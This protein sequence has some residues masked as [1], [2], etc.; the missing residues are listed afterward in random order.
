M[1]FLHI[2]FLS[3]PQLLQFLQ[4]LNID[5]TCFLL[6]AVRAKIAHTTLHNGVLPAL[7][8][9]RV[10]LAKRPRADLENNPDRVARGFGERRG[11]TTRH[12]GVRRGGAT[13]SLPKTPATRRERANCRNAFVASCSPYLGVRFRPDSL[14]F[15]QLASLAAGIVFQ[16]A[17]CISRII[18]VAYQ[19]KIKRVGSRAYRP[20]RLLKKRPQRP[21]FLTFS[22]YCIF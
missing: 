7:P 11:A 9:G 12:T 10:R 4:Q 17:L 3:F 20:D 18:P 14:A 6:L 5:P 19:E 2:A 8:F 21:Y 15:R 1:H 22:G 16:Q 13:I